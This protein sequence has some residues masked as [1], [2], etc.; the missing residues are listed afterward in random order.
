MSI[1]LKNGASIGEF[2]DKLNEQKITQLEEAKQA[3]LKNIQDTIDLE[4]S[5]Q[6]LVRKHRY[7]IDVQR[8]NIAMAL[9]VIYR[10]WLH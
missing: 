6:A 2:A 9:E 10:E 5:Q 7:L 3:S 4:K 1:W 8:N